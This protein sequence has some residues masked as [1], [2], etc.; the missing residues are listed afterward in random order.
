MEKDYLLIVSDSQ[1]NFKDSIAFC[2]KLG[3][4]VAMKTGGCDK[5]MTQ[6]YSSYTDSE[7]EG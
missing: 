2:N 3:E 7:N 4:M 5:C 6:F 1:R